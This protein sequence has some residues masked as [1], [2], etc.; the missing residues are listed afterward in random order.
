MAN[1]PSHGGK[2]PNSGRKPGT[3]M[4]RKT[5]SRSVSL[6]PEQWDKIDRLSGGNRSRWIA[7]KVD[8]S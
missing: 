2:R 8:E 3:G 7:A 5:V 6:T 4:G 1:N